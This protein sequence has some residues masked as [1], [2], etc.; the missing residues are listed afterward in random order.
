MITPNNFSIAFCKEFCHKNKMIKLK[1][2]NVVVYKNRLY[3]FSVSDLNKSIECRQVYADTFGIISFSKPDGSY[4]LYDCLPSGSVSRISPDGVKAYSMSI[5]KENCSM[6][7][8][9]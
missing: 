5:P 3:S 8:F 6:V 4:Y 7:K 1:N 9:R 2:R